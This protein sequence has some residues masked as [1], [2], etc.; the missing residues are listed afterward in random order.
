MR[1]RMIL[2]SIF[3]LVQLWMG[4]CSQVPE[5]TPIAAV[6]VAPTESL[7]PAVPATAAPLTAAPPA[8]TP[9]PSEYPAVEA[10]EKKLEGLPIGQFFDESFKILMLRDPESVTIEGL[11]KLYSMRDDQLTNMS[12]AYI[13]ETQAVQ[14]KIASLLRGYDRARLTYEQ[15]ISYDVYAWYLDDLI[16]QHA[17][18]YN[19]YPINQQMVS[20][21]QYVTLLLFT[22]FQPVN[23]LQEA[24]D[25]VSRL[26]QVGAKFEQVMDG[27]KRR[28]EAGIIPPQMV[29]HRS[30][31][32]IQGMANTLSW[33]TPYY[34]TLETKVN[35]L[36]GVSAA[37]KRA[38]LR[39]AAEAIRESVLPGYQ[40]LGDFLE[41]QLPKAP[42][43]GGLWQYSNGE[44]YY[45]EYLIPHM[46]TG[47]LDAEQIHELGLKQLA[48]IQAEMR[49][50][51]DELGYPQGADLRTLCSRAEEDSGRVSSGLIVSRYRRY[52]EFAAQNLDA[53]F[54]VKPKAELEVTPIVGDFPFYV[55]ASM[56][57][58]RPGTFF[59]PV[60]GWMDNF[61]MPTLAYHEGI[62]G[63]HFQVSIARE[64]DLPLFRNVIVFNAYAEGWALYAERLAVELG[65]YEGDP[66]GNLGRLQAE[67]YRAGRLAADTG[68]H[69]MK[70]KYNQAV[71]FQVDNSC[72]AFYGM[73]SDVARYVATPAQALGYEY[74]LVKILELRQRAMDQ[75]G[76]QFDLKEFHNVVLTNGSMPLSVLEG[77]VDD[78]IAS[79]K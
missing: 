35:A 25:Y 41:G 70:W 79:K 63:H 20:G 19:D 39:E 72:M 12:D 27:L 17:F 56:D 47:E 13:R 4:G 60:G 61:S 55:S 58:K 77:V 10:A 46:T 50:I 73:D 57:G 53:A 66:Y 54:D 62:P 48:R 28:E 15:Q 18:M 71:E 31:G 67:A 30:L 45:N 32:H 52:L 14:K 64:A 26:W 16:R 42:Q 7:A 76:E 75:L 2:I 33:E 78:Y 44:A 3:V 21:V 51:F 34:K 65:W 1:K 43:Q 22:D 8:A 68:I 69:V 6:G 23:D 38:V 24:R 5:M 11:S 59:A 9:T 40:A 74:G 49:A 29:I 37:E 36:K